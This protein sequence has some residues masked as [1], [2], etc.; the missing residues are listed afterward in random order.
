MQN[1]VVQELPLGAK[2]K[3]TRKRSSSQTSQAMAAVDRS[4]G[5]V[6]REGQAHGDGRAPRVSMSGADLALSLDPKYYSNP[7]YYY[8]W[9]Y[10]GD[11]G[12]KIQRALAAYYDFV[13]D[14]NGATISRSSG[15]R[16]FK[17]MA[18]HKKYRAEDDALKRKKHNAMIGK[19]E[20][21]SLGI[22]GLEDYSESSSKESHT[23]Y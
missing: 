9:F 3:L 11:N 14:E 1:D 4:I 20:K 21:E 6:S 22:A 5:N 8:R 15:S 7:D 17:L 19:Q 2:P 12:T 18:L 10:E 23:A 16:Q 13:V